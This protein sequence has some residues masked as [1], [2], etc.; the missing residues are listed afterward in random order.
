MYIC[1]LVYRLLSV[2]LQMNY[3]IFDLIMDPYTLRKLRTV[4]FFILNSFKNTEKT[5]DSLEG[6]NFIN[7]LSE[8]MDLQS[9]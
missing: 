6:L 5:V 3:I 7:V 4:L 9:H 8:L 1:M 2:F